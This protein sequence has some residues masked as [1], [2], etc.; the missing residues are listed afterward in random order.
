MAVRYFRVGV[1][2]SFFVDPCHVVWGVVAM[3]LCELGAVIIGWI[4]PNDYLQDNPNVDA[5]Y[6]AMY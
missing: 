1:S 2:S 4:T 3:E 6:G 5:K